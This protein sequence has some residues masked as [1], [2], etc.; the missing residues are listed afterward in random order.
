MQKKLVV[1]TNNT[2]KLDEI[3]DLL[4]LGWLVLGAGDVAPGVTWEETGLTFLENARIKIAALRPFTNDAILAD[5]SGLSVDALDGHPGVFSSSYGGVEGDHN[6]NVT[7]LLQKML[8][9]PSGARA[10]HFYCLLLYSQAYGEESSFEGRCHGEISTFRR[11]AGGF[12]YDPVFL[13]G[14]SGVSMA[15]MSPEE[16]NALSHRGAAMREFVKSGPVQSS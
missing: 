1:A 6:K 16:K 15:E 12:G 2:H 5:D 10:A 8:A 13:V 7:H 3:R 4:G 11:G 14:A 9:V